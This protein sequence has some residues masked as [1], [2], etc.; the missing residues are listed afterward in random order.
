MNRASGGGIVFFAREP[1]AGHLV[2]LRLEEGP[3]AGEGGGGSQG[4]RLTVAATRMMRPHMTYGTAGGRQAGSA[5]APGASRPWRPV[6]SPAIPLRSGTLSAGGGGGGGGPVT[7]GPK[8]C[9]QC[10]DSFEPDVEV[11]PAGRLGAAGAGTDGRPRGPGHRRA[12][13]HHPDA[14]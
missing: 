9:P 1:G 6:D 11:L 3:A 8:M 12:I 14:G 4:D 10:G 7:G 2:A 5:S 13:S